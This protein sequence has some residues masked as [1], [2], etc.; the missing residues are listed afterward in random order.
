MATSFMSLVVIVVSGD[1]E[2]AFAATH[3]QLYLEFQRGNMTDKVSRRNWTKK[4]FVNAACMRTVGA[5]AGRRSIACVLQETRR[6][7]GRL[8][9]VAEPEPAASVTMASSPSRPQR[10]SNRRGTPS[11]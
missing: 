4:G 8:M 3:Q 6:V 10:A 2:S 7:D 1:A 11:A 9:M 5:R